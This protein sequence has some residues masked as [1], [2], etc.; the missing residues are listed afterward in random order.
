MFHRADRQAEAALQKLK[1]RSRGPG[2]RGA[3]NRIRHR[4]FTRLPRKSAEQLGDAIQIGDHGGVEETRKD[5]LR[6]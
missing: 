3:G 4:A 2:L 6:R 1:H 5:P